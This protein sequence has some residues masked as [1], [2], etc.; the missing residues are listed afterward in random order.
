MP[1]RQPACRKCGKEVPGQH[2]EYCLDCIRHKRTFDS[3]AAL[4]HYNDAARHSLAAVKYKNR[5]EY[6][7]FYGTAMQYRFEK[8][9]RYW[10][11][12]MLIPVPIHPSR[13]RQRGYNQAEE[14]AIRLGKAWNIPVCTRLLFRARKTTPQRDLNPT[15]RLKNLQEAFRVHPE[16]LSDARNPEISGGKLPDCVVLIDDIY[17]TGST[18]EACSRVLKAA[19]IKEIHYLSICIGDGK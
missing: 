8:A 10:K 4:F 16:F 19:G 5:R 9:I 7:D 11:P 12:D 3:G 13:R 2:H 14:L 17:T 1:V 6:L 18:I 15:E